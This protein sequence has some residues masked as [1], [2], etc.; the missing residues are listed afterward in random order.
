VVLGDGNIPVGQLFPSNC[1]IGDKI[2][3]RQKY[4]QIIPINV[5]IKKCIVIYEVRP[6]QGAISMWSYIHGGMLAEK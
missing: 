4:N 3:I 2:R 5:S 1:N 6:V